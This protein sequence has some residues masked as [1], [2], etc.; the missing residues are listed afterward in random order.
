MQGGA[1]EACLA[2]N[3]EVG[4]AIPPPAT[5][6][7]TMKTI[8]KMKFGSHLYGTDT[9]QSDLD[10]K[11]VFQSS[12]EDIVLGKDE[13]SIVTCTKEK[14]GE[15]IRNDAGDVDLEMK[16]LRRFLHDCQTGQ[17]YALDMLFAPPEV[18]LQTSDEWDFI[19]SNKSELLS[20]NVGPY[21]GYCRKQA[22][23]Y[24][25]K[26]SR[27]GELQRVIAHLEKFDDKQLLSETFES[28]EEGEFAYF[29]IL[30]TTKD[31]QGLSKFLNVLGK[32]FQETIFVHQA[33][34]SMRVMDEKYGARARL[35]MDNKG[36]DW[37]AI[38]HAY[39]CCYQLL[40]LTQ[41]GEI[42]FPLAQAEKL[43]EIKL[44]DKIGLEYSDI[45]DELFELMQKAIQAVESSTLPDKPNKEFWNNWILT[46]YKNV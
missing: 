28:F 34:Y 3:Q 15:G 2:H 31:K 16:E 42:K 12:Y 23:K 21:I 29:E 41:T 33:L 18:I 14:K 25:L 9:P 8:V 27:L 36:I 5:K 4:G 37:K 24:G 22:G 32:K 7:K 35:A 39:R 43:K 19:C 26:G 13:H 44:G 40:E 45:Q 10:Y 11:G 1:V 6:L 20:K 38:S 30:P 17:T 46:I